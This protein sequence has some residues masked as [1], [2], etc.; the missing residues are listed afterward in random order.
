MTNA[1][2]CRPNDCKG[3]DKCRRG[4]EGRPASGGKPQ[5]QREQ[6]SDGHDNCPRLPWKENDK[7]AHRGQRQQ[8]HERL[9][10]LAPRRRIA[11]D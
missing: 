3:N 4:G 8:R 9:D 7:A 5:Q 11:R 10:G 6:E 1:E 2:G